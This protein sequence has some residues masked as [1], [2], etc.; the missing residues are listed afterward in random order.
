MARGSI[1]ARSISG[2]NAG[3][4]APF[5]CGPRSGNCGPAGICARARG[6]CGRET[7]GA[8][9]GNFGPINGA[10]DIPCS[11]LRV[12]GSGAAGTTGSPEIGAADDATG[13][14]TAAGHG[15]GG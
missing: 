8:D 9:G 6:I 11:V 10:A 13:W 5:H 2:L 3:S 1:I 7:T 4:V 14:L 12:F 15:D